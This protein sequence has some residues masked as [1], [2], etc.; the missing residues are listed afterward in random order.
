[1]LTTVVINRDLN[2][3]KEREERGGQSSHP[4]GQNK[5]KENA[6]MQEAEQSQPAAYVQIES[7]CAVKSRLL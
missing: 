3:R 5:T 7:P 2:E 4:R 6:S 1:M